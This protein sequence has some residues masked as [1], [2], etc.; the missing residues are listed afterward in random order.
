MYGECL[1]WLAT[2]LLLNSAQLFQPLATFTNEIQTQRATASIVILISQNLF[3]SEIMTK[4]S[5]VQS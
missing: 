2:V 4:I 1:Q 5:T 3:Q